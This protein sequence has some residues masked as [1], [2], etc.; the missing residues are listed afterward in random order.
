MIEDLEEVVGAHTATPL[1]GGDICRA[2]RI[3]AGGSRF[4]AKTPRFPD[5]YLLLVEADG[6]QRLGSAVPGLVPDVVHVDEDWLVLEWVEMAAADPVVAESLGRMLAILHAPD[7]GAFGDGPAQGRIGSL[8]MPAGTFDAWAPMYAEL[9]LRPLVGPELPACSALVDALLEEPEWAGP[10]ESASLLHGDL[11]AGNVLWST[12]PRVIDP[13]CH[14]G[15]RETDLAMLALF[16]TPHLDRL[17]A[18]YQESF[19]LAPGWEYRVGLHQLWPLLVH[20]RL[21]GGGYGVRAEGVA[22]GYLRN[23]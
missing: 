13:A 16:G 17:L 19:P 10:P 9:R 21:F 22:A 23:R 12:H 14:V 18:A 7:A 4:F 1:E 8:A 15:H 6:L 2:F 11:W 20:A 3:D 5:P